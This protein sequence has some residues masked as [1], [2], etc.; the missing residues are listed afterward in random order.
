MDDCDSSQ[1]ILGREDT[2][3]HCDVSAPPQTCV[4]STNVCARTFITASET[5]EVCSV[6]YVEG[7]YASFIDLCCRADCRQEIHELWY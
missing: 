5:S 1:S 3:D 6:G 7:H 4:R 2:A